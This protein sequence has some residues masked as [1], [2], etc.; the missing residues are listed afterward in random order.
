MA[1]SFNGS[2]VTSPDAAS[3]LIHYVWD[4]QSSVSTNVGMRISLNLQR[5]DAAVSTGVELDYQPS[6]NIGVS[7]RYQ[8]D[9][10]EIVQD[11]VDFDLQTI[12]TSGAVDAEK[13]YGISGATVFTE[14]N[15]VSGKVETGATAQN[16][17]TRY[18]INAARQRTESQNLTDYTQENQNK[19]FFTN[20]PRTK[21]IREGESEFIRLWSS[22]IN[23]IYVRTFD[24]SGTELNNDFFTISNTQLFDIGVGTDQ[25]N[26]TSLGAGYIDENV[27]S[28]RIRG[29]QGTTSKSESFTFVIDRSCIEQSTRVHFLNRLGAIDS[30]TFENIQSKSVEVSRTVFEQYISQGF[31]KSDRGR[32]VLKA[33]AFERVS[34][35]SKPL[36]ASQQ[37]WLG[38]LVTSP[39]V[40]IEVDGEYVPV[41][42]QNSSFV[43]S[44]DEQ[45]IS[46]LVLDLV[47]SND[48]ILQ[49]T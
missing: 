10:K 40:W 7:P 16:L 27:H 14:L 38:E 6:S 42:V 18:F 28:Y 21:S 22:D 3:A 25:I 48:L 32:S 19:K 13:S 24:E 20:A 11:F 37:S 5:A 17:D 46:E 9:I 45:N 31:A 15:E 44:D 33:D 1:I 35:K 29:A 12:G 8:M 34:A 2:P 23:R 30:Y 4:V 36:S 26:G 39:Q 41:I 49:R 43:T 47:Y